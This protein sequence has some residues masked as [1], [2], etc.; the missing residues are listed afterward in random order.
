MIQILNDTEVL[1]SRV[2]NLHSICMAFFFFPFHSRYLSFDVD[3]FISTA[4][5]GGKYDGS[6]RP[7]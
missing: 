4:A 3:V 1:V 2:G 6:G 7:N 5:A